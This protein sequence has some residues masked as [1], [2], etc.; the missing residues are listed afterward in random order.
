MF[1]AGKFLPMSEMR[2]SLDWNCSKKRIRIRRQKKDLSV[3]IIRSVVNTS[4]QSFRYIPFR[5]RIHY[6][7]N[8]I[9]SIFRKQ[10]MDALKRFEGA[11]AFGTLAQVIKL[12]IINCVKICRK[13]K[14]SQ[15]HLN[16]TAYLFASFQ[17]MNARSYNEI[18]V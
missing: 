11:N 16:A 14:K 13:L 6:F 9:L 2:F 5:L 15:E 10:Q 1:L 8:L 7:N 4:T 18:L 3:Y 12:T 17:T